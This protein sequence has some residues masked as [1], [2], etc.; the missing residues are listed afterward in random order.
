MQDIVSGIWVSY[1]RSVPTQDNKI[2]NIG[3]EMKV[4][5]KI[6]HGFPIEDATRKAH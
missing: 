1:G 2:I 6:I 5:M 4:K 3:V